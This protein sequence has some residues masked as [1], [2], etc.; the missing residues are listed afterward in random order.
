[1]KINKFLMKALAPT[2]NNDLQTL[3]NPQ[4][5]YCVLPYF[6]SQ[7]EKLKKDVLVLLE[8]YFSNVNFNLILV[9]NFRIANLFSFKDKLPISMRSSLVYEF[10]CSRCES[11]YIGSTTRTLGARVA[12][13]IGRSYRTERILASPSHSAIRDHSFSC[14]SK[15]DISNFKI[16]SSLSNSF[17]LRIM[18]SLYIFK[19]QP[20]LND[21]KSAVPL[22]II[23][24]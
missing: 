16:L 2:L 14:D 17:D 19:K 21:M 22:K 1:M 15:V 4:I 10:S 6:G 9:N 12:E 23:K 8:K 7:S 18:E 13:H 11:M 3:N 5:V 24:N 20:V